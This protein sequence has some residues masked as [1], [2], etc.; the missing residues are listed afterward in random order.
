[1][2]NNC[3]ACLLLALLGMVSSP[4]LAQEVKKGSVAQEQRMTPVPQDVA[5]NG[6]TALVRIE[7]FKIEGNT[8]LDPG[9]IARVL[10]PYKGD[11]RGYA[12]I[13]RALEALEGEYRKAGYSAVH[14]VTP[15]Q[16]VAKGTITFQVIETKVGKVTLKGNKF[17][18]KTNIRNALPALVEGYTPSARELSQNIRLA[19]E[20]PTRQMDVVLA[21]GEEDNTVDATVNVQDSSPRKFFITLD[22]T[23]SATTGM[24]RTG[25]GFQHNNLFNRDQAMT[26]NYVTSPDHVK[27]VTQLSASYR[28]PLYSVGDSIDLIVAHSDTNAG[29]SPIVGGFLLTFSGKGD[30]YGVHYN[31]YLPRQGDYASKIIAGL[32]YR[33]YLNNCSLAGTVC[34]GV[35]DMVV[36]PLTLSYGGTLTKPTR[37]ID[38]SAS[39]VHNLPGGTSG[40]PGVFNSARTGAKADYTLMRFNGSLAGALP[41]DWQYRVAGNLQYTQDALV[42]Y[43][44]FGLVGANAVRGFTEREVSNDEGYVL[45][46]ELYSPELATK[47]HFQDG[48]FRLLGFV[49]QGQGSKVLLPGEAMVRN[50][51]GSYGAGFR[52]AYGKNVTASFDLAWV[53]AAGGSTTTQIGDHR[54]QVAVMVNW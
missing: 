3:L 29:T 5:P 36:F 43:E 19:N 23:G 54:G 30:V 18:D 31:H 39:I 48:S 45:N 35:P 37:I 12:D 33:S 22:N 9:L 24:Y 41:Q 10:E 32:D 11:N 21:L 49:D 46:F 47:L 8:L 6:N 42:S 16:E 28:M 13:Q 38:Y 34:A 44:S 25:V 52:Y 53:T 51:V 4:V 1:M 26:L 27:D 2:N 15:E 7:H 20:N 50:Q 40:G 17:Y 14:V